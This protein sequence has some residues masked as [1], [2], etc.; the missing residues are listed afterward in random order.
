MIKNASFMDA[1]YPGLVP[2][3]LQRPTV[4]RC[5]V[6]W[7]LFLRMWERLG[8]VHVALLSAPTDDERYRRLWHFDDAGR[9]ISYPW[10]ERT[11]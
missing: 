5:R 7:Q 10:L 4:A 1:G 8:D 11:R 6:F 3:N 2:F 9:R